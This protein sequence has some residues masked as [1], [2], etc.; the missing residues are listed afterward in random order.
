MADPAGGGAGDTAPEPAGPLGDGVVTVTA[1][2]VA[3]VA[4]RGVPCFGSTWVTPAAVSATPLTPWYR[5]PN[6]KMSPPMT[7]SVNVSTLGIS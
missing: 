3:V 7:S 5:W 4:G 6:P 1:G 2:V